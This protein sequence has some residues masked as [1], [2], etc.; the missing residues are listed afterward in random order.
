MSRSVRISRRH[1]LRGTLAGGAVSVGLPVLDCMLNANGTAL[2]SGAPLPVRYGT[3]FYGCGLSPKRW[4]PSHPGAL[5][6]LGPEL[7][8]LNHLKDK[9]NIYSGTQVFLDG[10]P[11]LVHRTGNIAQLTGAAPGA[12]AH[13]YPSIDT[14]IADVIGKSTR[15]RSLEASCDGDPRTSYS[16]R[17]GGVLQSAEVS[18]EKMYA[19]IFGPEFVDPN[20][21]DFVPDP[22]VMA[23][24][25]VLS[26]TK[27]QRDAIMRD[28][29]AG[30]RARL[31][32]YFTSLRQLEQQIDLQLQRPAPLAACT[33]PDAVKDPVLG[34][35]VDSALAVN[36][37]M[38]R[39][40]AHA[41][42]CDQ[43]RVFNL[44]FSAATSR[45]RFAGDA[46]IYHGYTHEEAV[47]QK[48][49]YQPICAKFA[50]KGMEGLA[51][52]IEIL[53]NF[54]EGDGSLLDR[55]LMFVCTDTGQ[56]SVHGVVD[57]PVMTAGKAGGAM[58]T[59][60]H[61]V[62]RGDPSTRVGL[63]V[64]QALKVPLNSWGTDSMQTSKTITEV[65]A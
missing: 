41:L 36:A 17:A 54:K 55:T 39:L 28:A 49:G 31:E 26:A 47:D 5:K 63:T 51:T 9:I 1:I 33:S 27:D 58:K 57:M 4:A 38:M 53:D 8:P 10:K 65:L 16:Y 12:R 46:T 23:H 48:V 60:L 52:A 37:L 24:R 7:A 40:M 3:W 45:L 44:T 20:N 19:R 22:Q 34:T 15:F 21:A 13:V 62:G 50:M 25:S 56:A 29:G 14:L 32:E 11:L 35:E 6:E 61:V 59:G 43:T 2:A 30:D 64:M 42:A 18:P